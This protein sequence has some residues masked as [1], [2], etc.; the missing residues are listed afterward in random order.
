MKDAPHLAFFRAISD[1]PLAAI[2]AAPKHVA[3]EPRHVG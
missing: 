1:I 3:L 2:E